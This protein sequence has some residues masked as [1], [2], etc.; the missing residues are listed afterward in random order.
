MRIKHLVPAELGWK[1][2]FKEPDGS[3]SMSRVIGWAVSDD[4]GDQT[5]V[6]GVIVD[7]RRPR[8]SSARATRFP[9]PVGRSAAT[10]T[11]LPSRSSSLRRRRPR[12]PSRMR[13]RRW[14][15]ACSSASDRVG[16]TAVR[17]LGGHGIPREKRIAEFV[18]QFRVEPGSKVT[19]AKNFDPSFKK[20]VDSK[21]AGPGAARERHRAA[22]GVPVAALRA[23]DPRRARRAPGARRRR[24]RTGRSAT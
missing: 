20:G 15:R 11:S 19:L 23:G 17:W 22:R 4:D 18:E 6:V 2:V 16:P 24:A 21:Q 3:E 14:P 5:E 10:A 8:R 7:P 1:V 12:L 13:R 9:R